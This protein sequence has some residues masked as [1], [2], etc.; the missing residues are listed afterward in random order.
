MVDRC[1]RC[2]GMLLDPGEL[3]RIAEPHEGDLEFSTL[4][5]E[6]FAHPDAYGPATC[7]R[8]S[9]Q[10]MKKVE[11]NIYTG[12][13]LDYCEGCRSFWLDGKEMDRINEEVR[14]LDE[15]SK[16]VRAP[17]MLW[18]AHFIWGLPR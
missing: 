10:T 5:A 1:E 16:D 15:E 11:F 3:D 8:C 7:P 2:G 13:I 14:A 6:T 18:F 9:D 4:D 17:A 12:I